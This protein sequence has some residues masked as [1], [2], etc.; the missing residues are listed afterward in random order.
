VTEARLTGL[1]DVEARRRLEASP[2]RAPATTS[3][4]YSS[5][6]RSN[7]LTL[8][9]LILGSFWVVIL[10]AGR[11]AD[12]LFGGVFGGYTD[13]KFP[14]PT[15]HRA[16]LRRGTMH[17]STI[18]QAWK[19]KSRTGTHDLGDYGFTGFMNETISSLST[20]TGS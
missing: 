13:I 14:F 9:N 6:V 18:C 1:T 20:I 15:A 7:T 2:P 11:P 3:R 17:A 16:D 5:I 10:A 19:D 4:S 8:F 12:G